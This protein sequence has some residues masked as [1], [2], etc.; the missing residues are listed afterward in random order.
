MVETLSNLPLE[1]DPLAS[2]VGQDVIADNLKADHF[3][4]C[5][6]DQAATDRS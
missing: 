2:V 1:N 4:G 3:K 5:G 6:R